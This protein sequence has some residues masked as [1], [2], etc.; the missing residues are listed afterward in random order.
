MNIDNERI[1]EQFSRINANRKKKKTIIL[2][3]KIMQY[4]GI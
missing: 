2:L 4:N 1:I 3:H